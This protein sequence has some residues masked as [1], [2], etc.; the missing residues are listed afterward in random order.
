[1]KFSI[2]KKFIVMQSFKVIVGYLAGIGV[3]LFLLKPSD[4][5]GFIGITLVVTIASY[6][7]YWLPKDI[8]V[9]N[10]VVS[11]GDC[12]GFRSHIKI[13]DITSVAMTTGFYR[14]VHITSKTGNTYILHPQLPDKLVSVLEHASTT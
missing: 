8:D 4:A 11:F 14:T 12:I 10:G 3:V 5:S 1:M 7:L 13:Q 9:S 6:F 2:D